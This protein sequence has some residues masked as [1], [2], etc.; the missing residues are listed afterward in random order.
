MDVIDRAV[1]RVDDPAGGRIG[2]TPAARVGRL[3]LALF[4]SHKPVAR[5]ASIKIDRIAFCEARSA[6]V[7][8]SLGAFSRTTWSS[9]R[10]INSSAPALAAAVTA[11][12]NAARSFGFQV[13]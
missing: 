9:R 5:K 6:S 8:R 3:V 1:K 7:T 13:H 11:T 4:L 2:V 10:D 12:S